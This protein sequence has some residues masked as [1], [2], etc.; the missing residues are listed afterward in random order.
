MSAGLSLAAVP[1]YE[2]DARSVYT[3]TTI[4]VRG[5]I[6]RPDGLA[7][8]DATVSLEGETTTTD[9]SGQFS[10]TGLL[11]NNSFLEVNCVGYKKEIIP[12]ALR[13]SQTQTEV[14]IPSFFLIADDANNIRFLFG[15]DTSFARRFL[16]PSEIT[17]A[18]EIPADDPD[19]L[20]QASDPEQ[21][22]NSVVQY[23]R[24]FYQN[25]DYTIL[26]FESPVTDDPSTPH[27]TKDYKYFSLVD[28]LPALTWLG[29]NYVSLG[30]NH[31]YD[32]LEAGMADTLT[33]ISNLGMPHSGAGMNSADAFSAHRMQHGD[34][35]YSFLSMTSVTG[36]QHP[37]NYVADA[38]KGGAANLTSDIEV[39]AALQ[40]E[41]DAG[42]LPIVQLHSGKEYTYSPSSYI[43]GRFQLAADANAALIIAH[44]PHVAQG[45]GI[46]NDTITVHCLGNL[47]FDQDRLDTMLGL[48]AQ[49]D[50]RGKDVESIRLLPV[51]IKDYR[52][53]PLAGDQ[54][55]H[56]L[57]RIGE[58]STGYGLEVF[59]Y[60]GQIFVE[61]NEQ[62]VSVNE[63][64]LVLPVT[65]PSS[66]AVVLDLRQLKNAE[67]SLYT[68]DSNNNA[69]SAKLGRDI[70]IYGDF[71]NHAVDDEEFDAPRWDI[72][73]AS[74]FVSVANT[75]KGVAGLSS[76]R[77][78]DNLQDSIIP[79]RN[80][81]RVTG[82]VLHT[83]LKDLSFFGYLKGDNAGVTTLKVVYHA[84]FGE[85]TFGEEYF[86]LTEGSHDW[87]AKELVLNMPPDDPD[88]PDDLANNA[89]AVRLYLRQSPPQS[90]ESTVSFDELALINWEMTTTL[91]MATPLAAV[92]QYDFVKVSGDPGSY[93]L[94]LVFRS[95]VPKLVNQPS[96]QDAFPWALFLAPIISH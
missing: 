45:I 21:G 49:V 12:I 68:I 62:N 88:Y 95:Y 48:L 16:D 6:L 10:F 14:I 81:I 1:Q 41:I 11:R 34:S 87:L 77:S 59:P 3:A 71:E 89:R 64:Q 7:L 78:A 56:F 75:M 8:S 60:L 50:M 23:I 55:L 26:N 63:R 9:S 73:G 4:N 20:I 44:H 18:D 65:I 39:Q 84:S 35:N 61:R 30:N 53:R 42:Y 67:E 5:K 93:E 37:I 15:G 54:A 79:F 33:H 22:A 38:T 29:V 31:V 25:G 13:V 83:P 47:A 80:R 40:A 91:P 2:L 92:N 86:P 94:S 36:A 19:A 32:Y 46:V 72:T 82:D 66:G 24:P 70:L 74:S 28:S 57:R 85:N 58:V 51:T 52:P 96:G 27:P 43:Q 69:I 76:A 90:G 17:P